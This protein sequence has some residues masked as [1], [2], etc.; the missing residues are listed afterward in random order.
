MRSV[1]GVLPDF[2]TPIL[3][4]I[5]GESIREGPIDIHRLI[6]GN[7]ASVATNL[8]GGRNGHLTLTMRAGYYMEQ[9]GFAFVPPHNPCDYPQ[10]MRSAQEQA[11]GTE[12]FRSNQALFQKYT[13]V[14]GTLKKHIVTAV[15]PVFLSPLMDHLTGFGQV[16]ALTTMQ[17]LFFSYRAIDKIDLKEK[18]V[19]TMGPYDP[20]EPLS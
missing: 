13:A 7:A 18:I 6:S 16:Y 1:E 15:E 8:G 19:K 11:L 2:L 4:K 10:R 9:T 14:D 17:H 3:P 5:D 12:I 20:T